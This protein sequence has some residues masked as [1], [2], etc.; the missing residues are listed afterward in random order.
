MRVALTTEF[1][2]TLPKTDLDIYDT[3]FRG[4]V[5]RCR[6]SGVAVYRLNLG[7]G[8]GVVT[9]GRA[10]VLKP[11]EAREKARDELSARAKGHVPPSRRKG[12]D[13]T[14]DAFLTESYGPWVTTQRRSG[15]HTL[16][17]LEATFGPSFGKLHLSKFE[18]FAIERWRSA[19]LRDGKMPVTVNRDLSALRAALAQ[20]VAWKLI[21]AHPFAEVKP[22]K[23]DTH[24][25]ANQVRF[26][27]PEEESRLRAALAARDDRRRADRDTANVWRRER[28]YAEWPAFGTYTDHVTPLILTA[29][30][31]GMRR[32]ELLA[33]T[34]CDVRLDPA[35]AARVRVQGTSAKTGQTRDIPLNAEA[36]R[37][38]RAW[39]GRGTPDPE[40][41]VFG[42]YEGRQ[43]RDVK[44]AWRAIV[45][46]AKIPRFRFHD[47]RHHFAS[48]LVMK[49]T[50]LKTVAALLGH[51]S[52]HLTDLTYTHLSEG[53]KAA[54]VERLGGLR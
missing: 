3:K 28:R 16:A 36:R 23:V 24:R 12:L 10:D 49:G 32:G 37:V 5:L 31:T 6:R 51:T 13:P 18:P 54:A 39:R 45:R 4:L 17:R 52:T 43:M 22:L 11:Q 30:N 47:L 25:H 53:H 14:L 21:P 38:L 26:L 20:A 8:R 1:V 40:A 50:D 7:R 46:E 19:R 29:L 41:L 48:W 15:E 42:G 44:T 2:R 33:L 34:W 27:T 9:L 35:D